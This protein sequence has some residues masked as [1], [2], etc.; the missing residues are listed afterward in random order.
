[1]Q[2]AGKVAIG[3]AAALAL[4]AGVAYSQ[5]GRIATVMFTRGAT[6]ALAADPI[7]ALPDGL[8]VILCGSG[9]PVPDPHRAGPCVAVIAGKRMFVVDVGDGATRNLSLMG[10][11]PARAEAVLLTHFHSDHIDGLGGFLLQHWGAGS[12]TMPTPVGP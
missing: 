1:M 11:N 4:A 6:E 8:H 5:R 9:S 10:F 12:A 2:S 3:V 7:A